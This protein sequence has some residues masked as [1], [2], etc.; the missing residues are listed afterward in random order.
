ME[1]YILTFRY[2]STLYKWKNGSSG[3]VFVL[4]GMM[5]ELIPLTNEPSL[6]LAQ[7]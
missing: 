6:S 1:K 7:N 3:P 2:V 5:D 4:L